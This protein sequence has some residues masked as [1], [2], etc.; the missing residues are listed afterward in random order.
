ML[1]ADRAGQGAHSVL[2]PARNDRAGPVVGLPERGRIRERRPAPRHVAP[3]GRDP[4]LVTDDAV[5]GDRHRM[6]QRI[7]AHKRPQGFTVTV[8][9][10]VGGPGPG[11]PAGPAGR[12]RPPG[13]PGKTS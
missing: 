5:P 3:G 7:E 10:Q 9:P 4:D 11:D 13:V 8:G 2:G 12:A 6:S 1:L